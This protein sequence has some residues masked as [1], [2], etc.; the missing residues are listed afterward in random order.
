[1]YRCQ[2]T[3]R[4]AQTRNIQLK[5]TYISS[6]NI[7]S[8]NADSLQVM[9]MCEAMTDEGH[10]VR[11]IAPIRRP[12]V[13]LKSVNPVQLYDLRRELKPEYRNCGSSLLGMGWYGLT[14]RLSSLGSLVYTRHI[15]HATVCVNTGASTVLELHWVPTSGS[16]AESLLRRILKKQTSRFRIVTNT[17]AIPIEIAER[18]PFAETER[19]VTAHNGVDLDR[20]QSVPNQREARRILNL[21]IDSPIAG[22]VGSLAEDKGAETVAR[23]SAGM[24]GTHFVIVGDRG[25][26]LNELRQIVTASGNDNLTTPGNVENSE[27]PTWLSACDILL[28]PNRMVPGYHNIHGLWTSPLKMF[29]YMAAGKPIIASDLPVLREVLDED[30]AVLVP[31][32]DVTSWMGAITDLLNNPQRA[33][34]LGVAARKRVEDKYTWRARVKRCLDGIESA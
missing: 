11:L 8:Y 1:M 3:W 15:A 12:D 4:A 21:P 17:Q 24:P 5:I 33:E 28:L 16:L 13:R 30:I 22:Y 20:F 2:S 19:I 7:P 34:S 26:D 9:K 31:P 23:L 25:G 32:T 18:F 27:V 6:E 10:D 14:A 29:E